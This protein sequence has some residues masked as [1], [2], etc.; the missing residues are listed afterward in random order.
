MA[1]TPWQWHMAAISWHMAGIETEFATQMAHGGHCQK[2]AGI[3][4]GPSPPLS[5]AADWRAL[6]YGHHQNSWSVFFVVA[7]L[8][9]SQ[10]AGRRNTVDGACKKGNP[11]THP[12]TL[13][14]FK[15]KNFFR[16]SVLFFVGLRRT[17]GP[18]PP[19]AVVAHR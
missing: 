9:I 7:C 11:L 5:A 15:I 19:P 6:S 14:L 4:I 3:E 18:P 1:A 17:D 8:F 2:M 16:L 10:P 13:C 12:V